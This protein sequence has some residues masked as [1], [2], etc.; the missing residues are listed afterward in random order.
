[1]VPRANSFLLPVFDPSVREGGVYRLFLTEHLSRRVGLFSDKSEAILLL[2]WDKVKMSVRNCQ[3]RVR[4]FKALKGGRHL[5][6][7]QGAGAEHPGAK[8]ISD[9]VPFYS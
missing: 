3:A 1:M 8:A 5:V 7:G 2:Q 9:L 4:Q 6:H